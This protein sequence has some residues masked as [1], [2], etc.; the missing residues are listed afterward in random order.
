MIK[1][2]ALYVLFSVVFVGVVMIADRIHNDHLLTQTKDSVYLDN[3]KERATFAAEIVRQYILKPDQSLPT[4]EGGL[5]PYFYGYADL[6]NDGSDE[7]FILMQ[8]EEYC[9]KKGCQGYLFSHTQQKLA[10]WIN[11]YQ[12]IL[13]ADESHNGW[14]DILMSDDNKMYRI[15]YHDGRYL[16]D[17]SKAPE[18]NNRQQALVAVG[19]ALDSKYYRKGGSNLALN[20]SQPI[21]DCQQCFLFS[22]NRYDES[23]NDF[24]LLVNSKEKKVS[25]YP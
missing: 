4:T 12:P 23:D 6:N 10:Q 7:V 3:D 18:F 14:R 5:S 2:G 1:Y 24:Y 11:I 25:M 20:Y 22:F 19:L 8:T 9:T 21:F 13:V 15:E 17:V 16:T